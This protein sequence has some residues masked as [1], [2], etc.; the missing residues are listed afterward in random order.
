MRPLAVAAKGATAVPLLKP[1]TVCSTCS[2]TSKAV[3]GTEAVPLLI[4]QKAKNLLYLPRY[5][6][7]DGVYRAF[8]NPVLPTREI[9]IGSCLNQRIRMLARPIPWLRFLSPVVALVILGS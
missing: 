1:Y 5:L 9:F 7:S 6:K 8:P 2:I 3:N 4:A